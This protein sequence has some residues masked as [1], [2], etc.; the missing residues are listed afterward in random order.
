MQ[1]DSMIDE[2]MIEYDIKTEYILK[3]SS[4]ILLKYLQCNFYDISLI[5]KTK[6][7]PE[8]IFRAM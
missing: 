6:S 7:R 5:E 3:T 2:R 4:Q 8:I 1:L